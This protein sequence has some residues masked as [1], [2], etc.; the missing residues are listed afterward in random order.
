[1]RGVS[2]ASFYAWRRRLVAPPPAPRPDP[3]DTPPGRGFE[4]DLPHR[5]RLRCEAVPDPE[6]LGR[7]VA[8]LA[9][10]APRQ[11]AV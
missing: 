2:S 4:I 7:F 10:L 6:W 9:G 5:V 8:A 1:V 11:D 3:D